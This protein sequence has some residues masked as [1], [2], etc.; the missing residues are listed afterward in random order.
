MGDHGS[1]EVR[2]GESL[3]DDK[4]QEEVDDRTSKLMG[5]KWSKGIEERDHALLKNYAREGKASKGEN[6]P[7]KESEP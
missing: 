7:K 3:R 1:E 5:E 4:P 6:K 2:D